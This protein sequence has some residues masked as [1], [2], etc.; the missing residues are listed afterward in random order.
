MLLMRN[1]SLRLSRSRPEDEFTDD[2]RLQND[3]VSNLSMGR[4]RTLSDLIAD[5]NANGVTDRGR[6]PAS[7]TERTD[8]GKYVLMTGGHSE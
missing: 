7:S 2:G 1:F 3:N 6:S 8:I 5:M 4:E